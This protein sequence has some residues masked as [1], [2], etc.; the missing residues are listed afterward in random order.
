MPAIKTPC[1]VSRETFLQKAKGSLEITIDGRPVSALAREFSTG[2]L[3]WYF[4]G[5]IAV[6]IDGVKVPCQVGLNITLN[7]S[8]ELP[9]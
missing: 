2:S 5:K 6:E 8:K 7:N 9:E 1:P 3:G 4:N